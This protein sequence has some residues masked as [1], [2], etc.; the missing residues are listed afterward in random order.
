MTIKSPITDNQ[1]ELIADAVFQTN[2]Q[3]VWVLDKGFVQLT[4]MFEGEQNCYETEL[5]FLNLTIRQSYTAIMDINTEAEKHLDRRLTKQ[6]YRKIESKVIR[7]LNEGIKDGFT[8]PLW[9]KND[10]AKAYRLRW[11]RKLKYLN[12]G[13]QQTNQPHIGLV[14]YSPKQGFWMQ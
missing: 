9:R 4:G 7:K 14:Y 13:I 1:L 3:R 2:R 10:T 5:L 11:E 12:T 8:P 6:L